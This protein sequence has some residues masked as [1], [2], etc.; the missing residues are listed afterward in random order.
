MTTHEKVCDALGCSVSCPV[1][2]AEAAE[3][4]CYFACAEDPQRGCSL[5]GQW[6]V[7]PG[8]RCL[9]HPDAPGDW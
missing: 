2:L 8:E 5:S 1:A 3:C 7:H 9:V 6:H 4:A